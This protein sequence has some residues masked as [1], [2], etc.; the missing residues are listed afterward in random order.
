MFLRK[1][2]DRAEALESFMQPLDED[3]GVGELT[4]EE[5][6]ESYENQRKNFVKSSFL[7]FPLWLNR[8]GR[9]SEVPGCR[10]DP[11]LGTVG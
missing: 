9:V 10:F 4:K 11:W 6:I 7:E 3:V 2:E 8:I 1:F 5:N